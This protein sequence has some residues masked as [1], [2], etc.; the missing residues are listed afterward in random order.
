M[1]WLLLVMNLSA[2]DSDSAI[3]SREFSSKKECREV[4]DF[5][6]DQNLRQYRIKKFEAQCF[7]VT[8]ER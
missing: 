4:A 8:K 6:L 2:L 7:E 1:V 3:Y 5:F